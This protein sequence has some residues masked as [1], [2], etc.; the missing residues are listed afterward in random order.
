MLSILRLL[1]QTR[2]LHIRCALYLDVCVERQLLHSHAGPHRLRLPREEL[3][4]RLVHDREVVHRGDEDVDL[5]DMLQTA[6]G[7]FEHGRDVLEDLSLC[8][9]LA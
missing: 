2:L 9:Q 5:Q 8:L 6:P 3:I 1:F 4:I 7:L